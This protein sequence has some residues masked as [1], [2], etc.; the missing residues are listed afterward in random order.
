L[1][2]A[3]LLFPSGPAPGRVEGHAP[4]R[5]EGHAPG[6]VEGRAPGR[7]EGRAPAETVIFLAPPVP[8]IREMAHPT[9]P[10]RL[11]VRGGDLFP[12]V[13]CAPLHAPLVLEG[14]D[15][16]FADIAAYVG[17]SDMIFR[18]KFVLPGDRFQ[19][20]LDRPGLVTLESEVRPVRRAY[21][22][23]IPTAVGTVAGADGRYILDNVP[24]G[25]HRFTAWND[26][27]GILDREMDVVAGRTMALDWEFSSTISQWAPPFTSSPWSSLPVSSC[28]VCFSGS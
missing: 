22:Y 4:G 7:I 19:T 16:V 21:V 13:S 2:P 6:R 14:K 24:P 12:R 10:L 1:L 23:V 28:G 11:E 27:R 3:L 20:T 15:D 5:I 8:E 9:K 26:A 25:R 18:R 17:V